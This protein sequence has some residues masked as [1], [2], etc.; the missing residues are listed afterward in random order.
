M[1]GAVFFAVRKTRFALLMSAVAAATTVGCGG[2]ES[3]KKQ[4]AGLETQ[5]TSMR[6]DQDRLE[7]RLAAVELASAVPSRA[8]PGVASARPS[9]EHPR[10]KVIHLSPDQVG[11][12]PESVDGPASAAPDGTGPRPTIRGTGDRIIK[13][14]DGDRGDETTQNEQPAP[15]SVAQLGKGS[16]GN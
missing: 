4:I 10:L 2:S 5:I 11:S 7:E 6:A 1:V 8:A 9:V 12:S 16:R 3:L 13:T 14:G 15:R